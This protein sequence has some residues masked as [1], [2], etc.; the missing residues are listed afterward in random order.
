MQLAGRSS[1]RARCELRGCR[2]SILDHEF[3]AS[4]SRSADVEVS[5]RCLPRSSPE[6]Q[7]ARRR[8]G[9]SGRL[10]PGE[11]AEEAPGLAPSGVGV[12][13]VGG[14][15]FG[16]VRADVAEDVAFEQLALRRPSPATSAGRWVSGSR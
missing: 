2:K 6:W 1:S 11:P 5:A 15:E 8:I 16:R 4:R 13:G 14:G 10:A 9:G 3:A 12:E 7:L